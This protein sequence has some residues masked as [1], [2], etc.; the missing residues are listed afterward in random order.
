MAEPSRFQI[1]LQDQHR[2]RARED[3]LDLV[4]AQKRLPDLAPDH[5]QFQKT[6]LLIRQFEPTRKVL[7]FFKID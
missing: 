3:R 5:L 6:A 1:Q 7:L 2:A 4:L